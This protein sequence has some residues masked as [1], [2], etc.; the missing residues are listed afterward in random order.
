[1]KKLSVAM[2]LAL[3]ITVLISVAQFDAECEQ[4]REDVLR[5]HILANS[6][7]AEDQH[8]KLMVRDEIIKVSEQ[9]FADCKCSDDAEAVA[10]N[11]TELLQ[12]TA[13]KVLADNGSDYGAEVKVGQSNFDTRHYDDVTLPAGTYTAVQVIIGDGAGQNWWCVMFPQMCLPAATEEEKSLG[14]GDEI[15]GNYPKYKVKFKIVEL[16]EWLKD[17]R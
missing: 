2:A 6:D 14:A 3:C 7:S 4:I 12:R 1:M 9:L 8:L 15:A 11:N 16:Y 10:R 13:E 17:M 5:L